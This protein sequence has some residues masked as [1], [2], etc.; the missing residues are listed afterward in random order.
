LLKHA[1]LDA[2]PNTSQGWAESLRAQA[3]K[4]DTLTYGVE[5]HPVTADRTF[6][7]EMKKERKDLGA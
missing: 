7:L 3:K 2:V 4:H 1:I 5:S 6:P